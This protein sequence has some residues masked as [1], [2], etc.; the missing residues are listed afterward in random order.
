MAKTKTI[1]ETASPAEAPEA[2][3]SAAPANRIVSKEMVMCRV[4]KQPIM[5]E[6][7]VKAKGDVFSCTAARAKAYGPLV[8]PAEPGEGVAEQ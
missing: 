8:A 3:A 5:T 7:G 6:E 4:V 1:T 2:P